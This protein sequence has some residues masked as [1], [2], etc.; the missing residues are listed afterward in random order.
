MLLRLK[1]FVST[2]SLLQ[3]ELHFWHVSCSY[4]KQYVCFSYVWINDGD[5]PVMMMMMIDNDND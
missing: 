4:I 5:D 1:S 2:L 3:V